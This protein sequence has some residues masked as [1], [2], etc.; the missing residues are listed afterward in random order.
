MGVRKE[1]RRNLTRI[2]IIRIFPQSNGGRKPKTSTKNPF[3]IYFLSVW[4][5]KIIRKIIF[6]QSRRHT[7]AKTLLHYIEGYQSDKFRQYDYGREKKS[8][9]VQLDGTCGLRPFLANKR[10]NWQLFRNILNE[11]V[12]CNIRLKSKEKTR[13]TTYKNIYKMQPGI[14]HLL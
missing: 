13:S 14:Q 6:L 8:I 1:S 12:D 3:F 7:S 9:D 10:T 11:Q 4:T 5:I 2:S